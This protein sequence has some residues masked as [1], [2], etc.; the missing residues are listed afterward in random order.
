MKIGFVI[1]DGM[2]TLDFA[3]VYD[4][5]TR[6][7]TMGFTSDLEYDVCS[8]KDSVT[9][10]E[11]LKLTPDKV[12]NNLSSYDYVIVPGG[13]GIAQ[14]IKDETFIGWLKTMSDK[15]IKV[16]VCGGSI[17]LGVAGFLRG[18][19]A[20]THPTLMKFLEKFTDK[21]S[22]DRVVDDGDVITAR[23]V[24]S[25]IDLGLYFCQKIAGS[26]VCKKIQEQ[27]DYT[28]YNV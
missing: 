15:T 7:K 2:T 6:L 17:L 14:L 22:T 23:G 5:V 11:G 4:A 10:F 16:S 26:E 21:I 25:S 20:T 9:S 28:T 18:K 8:N 24:T 3:G 19:R 12:L 13:N 1:F 27:M